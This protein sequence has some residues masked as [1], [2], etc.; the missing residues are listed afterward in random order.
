ML[1]TCLYLLFLFAPIA[2]L[3]MGSL[4]ES[5][6][7][8][9]LP[10]GLTGRWY[11]EL[12]A[13]PSFQRAFLTS[14]KVVAATCI[15]DMLIA[16]PLAYALHSTA[17]RGVQAAARVVTLLPIATPELVLGFGFILV[18]SS[19]ALPFIGSIWL[20]IAA[21]VVVTLPYLLNILLSDMTQL[22]LG[23]LERV[24]ATLGAPFMSRFFDIVLPLVRHSLFAGL[25][26]VSA[27]SIGEFQI[28]NLIAGFL[29]RTYPITL[30]Q[31]FYGATGF[32]CAATV[33]LLVLAVTASAAGALT[34]RAARTG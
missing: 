3:V 10:S 11:A 19:D 29:T 16:V 6:T 33:V 9:L 26:T 30:L 25:I 28:S 17:R 27:I 13:D 5:W 2:L 24:A 15:L 22:K 32:A 20:L 12:A 7:N 8:S 4:G 14:L 18:F 34:A 21:H 23:D 31:A 1:A